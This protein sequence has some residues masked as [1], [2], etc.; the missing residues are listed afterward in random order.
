M[1][2][3]PSRKYLSADFVVAL[4]VAQIAGEDVGR[5]GRDLEADEDHDQFVGRRP[6]GTGPRCENSI[7]A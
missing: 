3:D 1:A 5:D 6:S 2:N 4:V 7:S